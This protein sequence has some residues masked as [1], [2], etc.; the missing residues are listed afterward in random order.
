MSTYE[1][2]SETTN[3]PAVAFGLAM[4]YLAAYQLALVEYKYGRDV[5]HPVFSSEF[6]VGI[7]IN[8]SYYSLT[9]ILIA[10]LVND[11]SYHS[12]WSTPSSP[13]IN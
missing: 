13:K 10:N 2:G 5:T 6:L 11:W 7:N 8:L 4:A 9:I 1:T 3:W 12:T